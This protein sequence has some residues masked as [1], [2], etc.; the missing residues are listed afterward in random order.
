MQELPS[1]ARRPT[2]PPRWP[3]EIN[4]APRWMCGAAAACCCTCSTDASRGYATT[5]IHCVSRWPSFMFP[6]WK[7]SGK[8]LLGFYFN[9][10]CHLF[11]RLSTSLH[12]CGR[13]RPTATTSRPKCSEPDS[14]RTQRDEHP[15]RS[16]GGKPPRPSEQVDGLPI[17]EPSYK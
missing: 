6:D 1:P 7:E 11:V 8:K 12:L 13:C 4:S 2:W 10:T 5:P 16:S 17:E 3:E 9:I 15:R 14:R